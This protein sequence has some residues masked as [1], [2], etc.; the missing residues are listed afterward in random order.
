M[1][2]QPLPPT[3]QDEGPTTRFVYHILRTADEPLSRREIANATGTPDR[4]VRNAIQ[5]LIDAGEAERVANPTATR[6]PLYRL[7]PAGKE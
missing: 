4:S 6:T 5:N 1:T 3:V 2:L 7:S